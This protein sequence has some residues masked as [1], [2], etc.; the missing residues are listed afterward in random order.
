MHP[1]LSGPSGPT[2]PALSSLLDRKPLIIPHMDHT[3]VQLQRVSICVSCLPAH[4]A[5]PPLLQLLLPY[6][7][8]KAQLLKHLLPQTFSS[9]LNSFLHSFSHLLL[10]LFY[11][12]PFHKVLQL[13]TKGKTVVPSCPRSG[14][15]IQRHSTSALKM[16]D[17]GR[18]CLGTPD[19]QFIPNHS[20]TSTYQA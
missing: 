20:F 4:N 18:Y 14:Q 8:L 19:Q 3:Q 10:P 17:S 1:T 13:E 9:S 16:A 7:P 15:V 5:F 11:L 2:C 12:T 6:S